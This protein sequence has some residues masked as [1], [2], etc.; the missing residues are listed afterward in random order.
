MS[1]T[2]ELVKAP[3]EILTTVCSPVTEFNI[4]LQELAVDMLSVLLRNGGLALAANQVG[5]SKRMFILHN[6][7][8]KPEVFINPIIK[9]KSG[10]RVRSEGCLSFPN[11]TRRIIRPQKVVVRAQ[12]I[13]GN[14]FQVSASDLL[15]QVIMH[16]MDH[17]NGKTIF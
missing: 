15:A 2:L 3:N 7:F 14:F 10:G 1:N 12:D 17:L 9:S 4:E 6:Q 13:E 8:K 16:E 5:V 11:R